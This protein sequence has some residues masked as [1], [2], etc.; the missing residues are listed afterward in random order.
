MPKT[1]SVQLPDLLSLTSAFELNANRQCKSVTLGSEAWLADVGLLPPTSAEPANS[2]DVEWKTRNGCTWR[3]LRIGLW[4]SV[5]FPR[6]DAPQLRIAT[7]YLSLLVL[8]VEETFKQNPVADG[9]RKRDPF[10]LMAEPL[11]RSAMR[12]PAWYIR[13]CSTQR[14]YR[15]SRARLAADF[16]AGI[17]PDLESFVPLR[18]DASGARLLALM[19][20]HAMGIALPTD[21]GV[22]S[23]LDKLAEYTVDIVAWC[24]DIIALPRTHPSPSSPTLLTVL[25]AEKDLTLAGALNHA[26]QLIRD[27]VAAFLATERLLPSTLAS[28]SSASGS[29]DA[30]RADA[31]AYVHGLRDIIAGSV[32]WMYESG[33][34][35]GHKG[36]EVRAFGWVFLEDAQPA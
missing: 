29:E 9:D 5:C 27:A 15:L 10:A 4:A 34:Y 22:R 21:M 24:E 16:K 7:D 13:L 3:A 26:G 35:L 12:S 17:T 31:D 28:L 8:D 36:P 18:R 14:A 19:L 32:N 33:R 1:T 2:S 23:V 6:A 25:R 11:A 20:E 30:I